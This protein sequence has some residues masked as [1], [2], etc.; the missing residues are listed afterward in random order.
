MAKYKADMHMIAIMEK[1]KHTV[2]ITSRGRWGP[3]RAKQSCI[4]C[5]KW[6]RWVKTGKNAYEQ[7]TGVKYQYGVN[8]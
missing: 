6:I 8:R 5:G 4:E 1:C 2:T 3:H 7:R